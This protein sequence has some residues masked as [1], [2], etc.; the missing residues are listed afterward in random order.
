VCIEQ[1][2]FKS[3]AVCCAAEYVDMSSQNEW[4]QM[5]ANAQL[6]HFE[7]GER[8]CSGLV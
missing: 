5:M 8:H 2:M 6:I 7:S 4:R 1:V 3:G